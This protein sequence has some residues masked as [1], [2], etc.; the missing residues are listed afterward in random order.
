ME[1]IAFSAG[2]AFFTG[3]ARSISFTLSLLVSIPMSSGDDNI[4]Y[5]CVG[6]YVEASVQA[7]LVDFDS[8]VVVMVLTTNRII[9]PA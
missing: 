4:Y 1:I 2:V 9:H 7:L 6:T 8:A 3:L 5:Y